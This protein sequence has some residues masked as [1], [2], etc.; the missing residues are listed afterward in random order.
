MKKVLLIIISLLTII[1]LTG[2]TNNRIGEKTPHKVTNDKITMEVKQG[3]LTD[4]SATII[5]TNKTEEEYTFGEP[6]HLEIKN[7]NTWYILEPKED[8]F[9]TMPAYSLKA[10]E[11]VEKEYNWEYAYG[12]LKKG[13]Y[14]LV[15]DFS[16]EPNKIYVAAEFTIK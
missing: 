14:R 11:S 3:T 2:C 1:T 5:M 16:K 12:K 15:T 6:Y 9:F 8:L 13:T 7:N 10:G 4:S